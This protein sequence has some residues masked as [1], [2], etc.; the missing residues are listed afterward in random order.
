MTRR[1]TTPR[2]G[3]GV[4]M[5]LP[6]GERIGFTRDP[7]RGDTVTP[8]VANFLA[9]YQE[10]FQY[11]VFAFQPGNRNRLRAGDYFAAY[12]ALFAAAPRIGH[13]A[14]HHTLL[15]MATLE[16]I[17][18]DAVAAF[19]NAL[20]ERY[21]F[22][23]IVEDLGLW[24]IAGKSLPYPLPPF[25][26]DEGLAACIRNVRGWQSRLAAPLCVEFPGFTEGATITIGAMD[27]FEF[28]RV[29]AEETGS[30]VTLDVG[31]V[32]SYQWSQGR[33]GSRRFEALERL[34]LL[35]C[36]EIHLSGCQISGGKFRDLHHGVLLD[37]QLELLAWLLPRCPHLRAITYEDP[38]YFEG[39]ELV[40]KSVVNFERLAAMAAAWLGE[41]AHA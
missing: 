14:L 19:T 29:V 30:P 28:F 24:S 36:H 12:D 9:R 22:A 10:R 16:P 38:R 21:G 2:L 20:V 23:W 15:N 26:T 17:E 37:E 7:E 3:L 6:W 41:E 35:A 11:L 8:R 4:G 25:L 32:L 18:F 5:D 34:P 27:A 39:G 33:V 40:P 1:P 31:H 13:R